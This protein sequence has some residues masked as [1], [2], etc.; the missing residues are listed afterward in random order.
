MIRELETKDIANLLSLNDD[1]NIKIT[2]PCSKGE[3]NQWLMDVVNEDRIKIVGSFDDSDFS[4]V[5]GY[6]VFLN[7]VIYPVFDYVI[8]IFL[9]TEN[10][11]QTKEII[12]YGK[13]WT[14][15]LGARRGLVSFPIDHL[16]VD[17]Y[18]EIFGLVKIAETFEW[19]PN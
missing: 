1:D 15:E 6:G 10:H 8:V 4:K 3:W 17:K 19:R 11:R 14:K 9:W 5:K 2:L 18:V 7:N 12:D 13:D 16:N